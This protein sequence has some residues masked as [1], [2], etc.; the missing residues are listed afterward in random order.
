[1]FHLRPYLSSPQHLHFCAPLSLHNIPHGLIHTSISHLLTLDDMTW[2]LK[3]RTRPT[4]EQ[5]HFT[6][7][8]RH[9]SH[10]PSLN[11]SRDSAPIILE[12]MS[13]DVNSR[14]CH[15]GKDESPRLLIVVSVIIK[16]SMVAILL[17]TVDDECTSTVSRDDSFCITFVYVPSVNA[18]DSEV[19][20]WNRQ[21]L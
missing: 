2:L 11:D 13:I 21:L 7:S 15:I 14:P 12:F 5:W 16:R 18:F 17:A 9:S 19:E 4:L 1:M 8:H 10:M 3:T 6:A 20:G